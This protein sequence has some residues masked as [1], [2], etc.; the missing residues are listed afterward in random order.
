M[1]ISS[2]KVCVTLLLNALTGSWGG[3]ALDSHVEVDGSGQE[4]DQYTSHQKT[5]VKESSQLTAIPPK[6]AKVEER[7]EDK[8][9][10][11]CG[12]TADQC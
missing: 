10:N 4:C 11:A 1:G 7:R 2:G 8:G 9:K 12:K 6:Q 5:A 3:V